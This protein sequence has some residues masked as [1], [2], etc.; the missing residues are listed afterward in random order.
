[1]RSQKH[2]TIGDGRQALPEVQGFPESLA[3]HV[4]ISI[5]IIQRS[6]KGRAG[7]DG[8]LRR[9]SGDEVIVCICDFGEGIRPENKDLSGSWRNDI[10]MNTTAGGIHI[11]GG[12]SS[13]SKGAVAIEMKRVRLRGTRTA[14]E[15]HDT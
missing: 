15:D 11:E 3:G 4:R 6:T 12:G 8:G 5:E 1:M 2:S 7:S 9:K 10:I 13:G 14:V